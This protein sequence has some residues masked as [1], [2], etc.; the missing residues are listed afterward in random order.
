[1]NVRY[2]T[3]RGHEIEVHT[4]NQFPYRVIK[5]GEIIYASRTESEAYDFIDSSTR[6]ARKKT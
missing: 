5:S 6:E 3:Y 1:M 4:S 2:I